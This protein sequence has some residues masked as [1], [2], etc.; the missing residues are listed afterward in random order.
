LLLA[1]LAA[2]CSDPELEGRV[3]ALEQRVGELEQREPGAASPSATA[4]APPVATPEAENAAALV[5][6][7]AAQAID[8]LDWD[9]AKVALDKLRTEHADTRA[10]KASARL[11]AEVEAVGKPEAELDVERWLTGSPDE[12]ASAKATVY[13][14]WE[15]WCSHCQR[16]LPRLAEIYGRN[17]GKG[18]RVVGVTRMSKGVTE[19]QALKFVADAGADWPNA[20]DQGDTLH[21]YYN[22]T[23][24]PAAAVVKDGKVVWRGSPT[25]LTDELLARWL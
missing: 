9:A 18:L 10:A 3:Q 13:V 20:K 14:F 1:A 25:K 22:V 16:D 5:L 19:E 8:A 24:I 4:A 17:R 11:V 21:R 2:G 7:D 15:A 6:R 23:G 12:L